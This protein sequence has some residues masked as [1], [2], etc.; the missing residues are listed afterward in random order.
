[1]FFLAAAQTASAQA[2]FFTGLNNTTINLP[3][4]TGCAQLTVRVPHLKS[5]T[6][7]N[8]VQIP[9]TPF[10]YTTPTG[11]ELTSLYVD[12]IFS[13][14]QALGFPFCFYGA[15]Y[16]NA[17]VGSNGLITFDLTQANTDAS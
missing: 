1:M 4:G 6:A 11:T 5:T 12:D 17:V 13:P 8:L 2:G 3:C 16:S 7:Y 10:T 14:V 9:C 15:T